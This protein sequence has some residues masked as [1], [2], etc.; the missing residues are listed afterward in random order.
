LVARICEGFLYCS[1]FNESEYWIKLAEE[2]G[3]LAQHMPD[4]KCKQMM[5]QIAED[6]EHL[7]KQ[8]AKDPARLPSCPTTQFEL[9]PPPIAGARFPGLILASGGLLGWW[10]RRQKSA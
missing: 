1:P 3:V 5:L 4:D 9:P 2:R 6:Y 8:I 7:A 10:R